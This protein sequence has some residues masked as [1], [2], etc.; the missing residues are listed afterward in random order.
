M[1]CSRCEYEN[2]W[3]GDGK[4]VLGRFGK[5]Y[6]LPIKV[7]RETFYDPDQK[8]VFA[9]PNPDCRTLFIEE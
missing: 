9:C 4:E 2:G 1:K 5:F 3:N 6:K 7:E 8:R